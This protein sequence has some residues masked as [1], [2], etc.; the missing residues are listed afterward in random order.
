MAPHHPFQKTTRIFLIVGLF[1]PGFTA[2]AILGLQMLIV[3]FG[4]ECSLSW[5]VL[6][7]ITIP[8]CLILPG[9]FYRYLS[10]TTQPLDRIKVRLTLFNIT[11]YTLIQ[12]SLEPLFSKAHTLCYVSDGQ[13]GMEMV[14]TAW[15]A[16]PIILV[17]TLV[18]QR[19]YLLK[20]VGIKKAA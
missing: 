2:I 5:Y 9:I 11:E 3:L 7:A 6:W 19:I 20:Q 8:S 16:L 17:L 18:F 1:I 10:R 15:L 4:V 12:A 13:N 14:L